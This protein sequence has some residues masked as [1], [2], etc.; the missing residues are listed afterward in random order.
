MVG[1][2]DGREATRVI[3]A[4]EESAREGRPVGLS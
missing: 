3:L 1:Y 4:I 2:E